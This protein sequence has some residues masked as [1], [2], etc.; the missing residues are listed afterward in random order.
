MVCCRTF[1]QDTTNSKHGQYSD[2]QQVLEQDR[3]FKSNIFHSNFH[4]VSAATIRGI[5]GF[6]ESGHHL[7]LEDVSET[8][9]MSS[10]KGVGDIS[11]ASVRKS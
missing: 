7:M 2:K 8:G 4:C 10:G 11:V 6:L 5:N 9:S 3:I 1:I